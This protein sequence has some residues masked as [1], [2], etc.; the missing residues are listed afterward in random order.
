MLFFYCGGSLIF[1]WERGG[2]SALGK[3]GGMLITI[4]GKCEEKFGGFCNFATRE[5]PDSRRPFF[6][7]NIPTKTTI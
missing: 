5:A 2:F 6:T 7:Y 3:G 4:L 1:H